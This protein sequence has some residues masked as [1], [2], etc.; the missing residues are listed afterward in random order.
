MKVL[1]NLE[2][3]AATQ[4]L[5]KLLDTTTHFSICTL[6]ELIKLLQVTPDA[7]D[8]RALHLLH[9]VKWRDMSPELRQEAQEAI[10]R[11]VSADQDPVVARLKLFE[12]SLNPTPK[13]PGEEI[14]IFNS[15]SFVQRLLK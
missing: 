14:V 15:P 12:E 8:Y 6:D 5:K 1:T 9:C 7:K 13:K 10:M 4:A 3:L 11:I 2:R